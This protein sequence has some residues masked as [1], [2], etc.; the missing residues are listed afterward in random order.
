MK[1]FIAIILAALSIQ[2]HAVDLELSLGHTQFGKTENGIW[3]QNG[4]DHTLDLDSNSWSIGVTGYATDWM[5]WRAQWTQLGTMA[6]WAKG[7]NDANYNGGG[8]SC[9]DPCEN[10]KTYKT[11]GSLRGLSLTLA[12]EMNLGMGVKGF[13]EGG[14]FYNLTKFHAEA[15]EGGNHFTYQNEYREGWNWGTQLG[16]GLEYKKTQLVVTWYKADAPTKDENAIISRSGEVL[17]VAIRYRF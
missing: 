12:P 16:V 7:V 14:V 11:E 13:V 1:H 2:A 9:Y 4:F 5:R 6:T 17:N 15:S 8:A 3:Y 10:H